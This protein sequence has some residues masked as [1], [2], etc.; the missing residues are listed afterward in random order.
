MTQVDITI[1]KHAEWLISYLTEFPS[2]TFT[3]Q[4]LANGMFGYFN[5]TNETER[6]RIYQ[7]LRGFAAKGIVSRK[8]VRKPGEGYARGK[9]IQPNLWRLPKGRAV[10]PRDL[11]VEKRVSRLAEARAKII[12]LEA[13]IV[14][15]RGVNAEQF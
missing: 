5:V 2:T 13:E 3:T 8:G 9:T 7:H 4:D 11:Y 15:L 1:H 12:A 10:K 14:F 6:R